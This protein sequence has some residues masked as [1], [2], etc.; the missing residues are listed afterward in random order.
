MAIDSREVLESLKREQATAHID[1]RSGSSASREELSVLERLAY[2]VWAAISELSKRPKFDSQ[3]N[4]VDLSLHDT[5]QSNL[6]AHKEL[7][8][9]CYGRTVIARKINDS[10]GLGET[11]TYRITQANVGNTDCNIIARNLPL[12]SKLITARLTDEVE[13]ELPKNWINLRL[14]PKMHLFI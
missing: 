9:H 6:K 11:S 13:V 4:E 8:D 12:A 14:T 2:S 7:A 3:T 5:R 10:G 1:E